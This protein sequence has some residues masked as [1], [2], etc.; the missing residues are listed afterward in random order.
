VFF[1]WRAT[2]DITD[3]VI[4]HASARNV[5]VP[6]EAQSATADV[7]TETGTATS[8]FSRR[9]TNAR[10]D[11]ASHPERQASLWHSR[12]G[13]VRGLSVRRAGHRQAAARALLQAGIPPIRAP[14]IPS[15][16]AGLCRFW[17]VPRNAVLVPGPRQSRA[18][19]PIHR[20]TIAS[21]NRTDRETDDATATTSSTVDP[22]EYYESDQSCITGTGAMWG[23]AA[24]GAMPRP[25]PAFMGGL[26]TGIA[27]RWS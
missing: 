2:R 8:P 19:G 16:R 13:R 15:A 10:P 25:I 20:S 21:P 3:T 22:F 1:R 18:A 9:T 27:P 4:S 5:T 6:G 11:K 23:W 26:R 24:R 12:R 7:A 14:P 17:R